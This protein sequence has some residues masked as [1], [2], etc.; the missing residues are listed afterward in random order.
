MLPTWPRT[1][2]ATVLT[3]AVLSLTAAV[4]AA[5]ALNLAG[6]SPPPSA[7]APSLPKRSPKPAEYVDLVTAASRAFPCLKDTL[8]WAPDATFYS[9]GAD[10]RWIELP[11]PAP[12][13]QG[14][15]TAPVLTLRRHT[16]LSAL[17]PADAQSRRILAAHH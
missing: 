13:G 16:L 8:Y 4:I 12:K 3:A 11:G 7:G 9:T 2:A 5:A 17:R 15:D 6:G 10:G 1:L 14:P